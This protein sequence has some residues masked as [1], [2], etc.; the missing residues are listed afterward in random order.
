MTTTIRTPQPKRGYRVIRQV[1]LHQPVRPSFW[2][3]LWNQLWSGGSPEKVHARNLRLDAL[4]AEQ[5]QLATVTR[6]LRLP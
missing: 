3:S 4:A 1:R 5:Q 6:F 2:Q